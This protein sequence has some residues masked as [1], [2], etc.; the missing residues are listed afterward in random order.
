MSVK[1]QFPN[2]RL[3]PAS[4]GKP[5]FATD[6]QNLTENLL[7]AMKI[8]LGQDSNGFAILRGFNYISGTYSVGYV[9]MNG[10]FYY[11]AGGVTEGNYLVPNVTD[12]ESKLHNPDGNSYPTY[13][14]YYAIESTSP[15]GGMPQFTG[16][17]N[18][19]RLDLTTVNNRILNHISSLGTAA[20]NNT[21]DFDAAGSA[22]TAQSNAISTSEGY[23]NSQVSSAESSL[24]TAI[25]E[26]QTNAESYALNTVAGGLLTKV[27]NIGDWNMAM[28]ATKSVAH[29][30]T[31][32]NI[33]RISVLIRNDTDALAYDLLSQNNNSG[34]IA[35]ISNMI[36]LTRTSGDFFD[37]SSYSSTSYNRGWIM[38]EYIP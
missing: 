38:I 29:G 12:T 9:Y 1:I 32:S 15:W 17:M 35:R 34:A 10:D 3:T 4:L 30:V 27:I 33:R 37:N 28:D 36:V 6:I 8:L 19:Y 14:I 23:T 13:R 5:V 22:A 26:A 20:Y 7:D 16:D 31:P 25:G 18:Q 21:G 11:C 2:I 24:L